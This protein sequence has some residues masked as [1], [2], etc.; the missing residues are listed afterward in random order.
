MRTLLYIIPFPLSCLNSHGQ[1]PRTDSLTK[2]LNNN[3]IKPDGNFFGPTFYLS[4]GPGTELLKTGRSVSESLLAVLNDSARGGVAHYIL[5]SLWKDSIPWVSPV[6]IEREDILIFTL[7]ELV[8]FM[9]S[10]N[11]FA[12]RSDLELK[13]L[14]WKIFLGNKNNP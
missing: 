9:K 7:N 12:N 10:G 5:T 8:F 14:K 13:A 6:Y 4:N 3:E 1:I 11:V 2:Q